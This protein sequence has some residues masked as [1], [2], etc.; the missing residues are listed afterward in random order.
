MLAKDKKT[1]TEQVADLQGDVRKLKKQGDDELESRQKRRI[2]SMEVTQKNLQGDLSAAGEEGDPLR[3]RVSQLEET[4]RS[5]TRENSRLLGVMHSVLYPNLFPPQVRVARLTAQ[6]PPLL[7][8]RHHGE[9]ENARVI[10][11]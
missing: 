11:V 6:R 9:R 5:L 2:A 3:V 1:L 8:P 4:E 10:D 7:C